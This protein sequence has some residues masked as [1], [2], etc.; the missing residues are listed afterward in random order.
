MTS[1]IVQLIAQIEAGEDAGSLLGS[2]KL[3]VGVPKKFGLTDF[4]DLELDSR[5]K[6]QV[7]KAQGYSIEVFKATVAYLHNISVEYIASANED[8][9]CVEDYNALLDQIPKGKYD[10]VVG[11]VTI[12][13]NR[14]NFV[15]F[16]LPY[17]QSDVKIL[18][19]LQ[20]RYPSEYDVMND[21]NV[22]V[23]YEGGSFIRSILKS[24]SFEKSRV[25]KYSTIEQYK[26]ALDKGSN[27]GGI[28]AIYDEVPY[29]KVFLK[30]YG[31]NHAMVETRHHNNE[32]GFAFP[33]GCNLT[34][35]FSRAILHVRESIEMDG[36]EKKYFGS[37]DND[38]GRDLSTSSLD[39]SSTN[40][41]TTYSFAGLFMLIGILSLLA[42][43]ISGS[44][45]WRK[46]IMLAKT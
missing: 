38:K 46:P 19:K 37:S 15:D 8:G 1:F 9:S 26:E 20:P 30:H 7:K 25:K 3:M 31:P 27:K 36:I 10:A 22:K 43:L 12:M 45:I 13:A 29:I 34:S 16:T 23:G 17:T 33:K 18:V 14:S 39:D 2:K 41:L 42:L 4:V 44:C 21:H 11:N 28:D 24:L 5:N 6:S 32:F 40:R 35:H